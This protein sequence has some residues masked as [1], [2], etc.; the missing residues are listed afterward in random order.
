[1]D[2]AEALKIIRDKGIEYVAFMFTDF[3]GKLYSLWV[4]ASEVE[5]GLDH[6][7][8]FS[9][10]PYFTGH[11]NSDLLLKPDMSSFRVLPWLSNGKAQG[12]VMADIYP[13]DKAEPLEEVPRYLLQRAVKKL[14]AELG[15]SVN[16]FG[17]PECEFHLIE[18][19]PNGELRLHGQGSYFSS[20]PTD[21]ALDLRGEFCSALER[22]GVKIFKQHHESLR[23]KHEIDIE[24][25]QVVNIADKVMLNK[26]VLR[27]IATDH[28]L[29]I[30]FMPKPFNVP[31]GAGWH[32]HFSLMDDK[33][34]ENLLYAAKGN[35]GFT[36]LGLHFIAGVMKHS[37]ALTA[38]SNPAVNSY[39]RLIPGFQAP[40]YIS[41][42]KYNRSTLIR[43]P[44]SSPKATRFEYRSTDGLCNYYLFF[45]G[46]IYAGLDGVA[47]KDL[48]PA[49]IEENVY[50][51]SEKERKEKGIGRLPGSLGEALDE[52]RRNEVM[53]SAIHP[54]TPKFLR[55]KQ[56]E[57]EEYAT[58]VHEWERNKYME[59]HFT[60]YGE[61]RESGE[62]FLG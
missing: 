28:G 61:Y 3:Q 49:P 51:F 35:Y 21:K 27:K 48:P 41:W 1:M 22:M 31:G 26:M 25:D 30:T 39:K 18:K 8:G 17:A 7:T 11:N 34:G 5:S 16:I 38:L 2:K 12:A 20:P 32:T 42:A 47:K 50:A 14:K 33:T 9:G 44:A 13:A 45:A 15:A 46:L 43:V 55:L 60:R 23:G 4:H 52:L 56:E 58:R 36:D 59:E 6:G 62:R 37:K 19:A 53:Q 10:Y 54:L 40:I 29:I 24:Y 57:W